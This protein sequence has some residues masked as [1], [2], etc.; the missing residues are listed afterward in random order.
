MNRIV[1]TGRAVRQP[2]LRVTPGGTSVTT[3][4]VA[5]DRQRKADGSHETDFVDC[6]TFSKLAEVVSKYVDKGKL[7][8]V[9]GRLESRSW[10]TKEGEKRRVWEVICDNVQFLSPKGEGERSE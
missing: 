7:V 3:F 10:E 6:V 5:V 4:T 1:L 9:E 2:E 8:A